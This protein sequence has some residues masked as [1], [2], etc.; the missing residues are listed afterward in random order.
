MGLDLH[1]LTWLRIR[2]AEISESQVNTSGPV[3]HLYR[4]GRIQP[5]RPV[6]LYDRMLFV[7][8]LISE[9]DTL[10]HHAG[11]PFPPYLQPEQHSLSCTVVKWTARRTT[12]GRGCLGQ[13]LAQ[14]S[15]FQ[16][17]SESRAERRMR[18]GAELQAQA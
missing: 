12:Q 9:L 4:H 2:E 15:P 8:S 18:R 3:S 6:C 11:V 16:T 5:C 17:R 7:S 10:M 14:S 13:V 1:D